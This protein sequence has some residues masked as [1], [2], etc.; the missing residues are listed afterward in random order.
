MSRVCVHGPHPELLP[1][2]IPVV[3]ITAPDDGLPPTFLIECA[4][5]GLRSPWRGPRSPSLLNVDWK[6]R[7]THSS[8]AND[9]Y[10]HYIPPAARAS[11]SFYP[12][13]TT[14]LFA[15]PCGFRG[16]PLLPWSGWKLRRRRRFP[17]LA[18]L[19]L[20]FGGTLFISAVIHARE[21]AADSAFDIADPLLRRT[22]TA[23]AGLYPP[24]AGWVRQA[25]AHDVAAA[26]KRPLERSG[27]V[28]VYPWDL[29]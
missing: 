28:K 6:P 27:P 26:V 5:R 9:G 29:I 12:S 11:A 8:K 15:P 3:Y 17:P 16:E 2:P 7:P 22:P 1:N 23:E 18:F 13:L 20:L 10:A 4:R 25:P 14:S 19:V 24:P 21:Y